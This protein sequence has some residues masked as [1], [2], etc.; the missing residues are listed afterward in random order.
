M[1]YMAG[2]ISERGM[3]LLI[4]FFILVD[5]YIVYILHKSEKEL[6]YIKD[7][8]VEILNGKADL[9]SNITVK[10][11]FSSYIYTINK[12]K[13][14]QESE[15]E[16]LQNKGERNKE[17]LS[18][19]DNIIF[20]I[21]DEE[22]VMQNENFS[23]YVFKAKKRRYKNIVK[24]NS[25]TKKIEEIIEGGKEI[26]EEVFIW[27]V[28][29]HFFLSVKFLEMEKAL[30]FSLKDITKSKQFEQIQKDFISNVSHEL[31]TPLTNIKG[32]VIAIEEMVKYEKM[33]SRTSSKEEIGRKEALIIENFFNVIYSNI[34]KMENLIQ[35]FLGYSKFEGSKILNKMDTDIK[36][37]ISEVMMELDVSITKKEAVIKEDY[38]RL[39]SEIIFVD[40]EKLKIILKN[41]IEN[42]V[43][44]NKRKPEIEI[45][46]SKKEK[47]YIF[48]IKDNG[49]GISEIEQEKIFDRFYRVENQ[50]PI[51][52]S[53]SGLG[54]S[55]V[56]ET[57]E[58]YKGNIYVKSTLGKGTEFKIVLPE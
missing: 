36:K 19:I 23:P 28:N 47:N 5:L 25:L 34:E 1:F 10:K 16:E 55:I 40:R 51:N 18:N 17:I 12:I 15:K 4:I 7:K 44:Y 37:V 35:K 13:R 9:D 39:N 26:S 52:T 45:S 33:E 3:G 49:V 6:R 14:K 48:K 58:N 32:Y 38:S 56:K 20:V 42:L 57:V 53:G 54:L 31:K 11:H 46:V 29:K 43:F 30:L 41:I 2:H 50:N 24:Y 27:E 21:K 22:I 8:T